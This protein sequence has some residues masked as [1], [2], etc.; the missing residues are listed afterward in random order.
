[1]GSVQL[2]LK[3]DAIEDKLCQL[4]P[5]EKDAVCHSVAPPMP[6]VWSIIVTMFTALPS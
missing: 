5:W 3:T 4:S 2:S 6:R 1:M